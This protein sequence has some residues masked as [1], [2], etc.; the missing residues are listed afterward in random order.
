[1]GGL[2]DRIALL[3]EPQAPLIMDEQY[4]LFPVLAPRHVQVQGTVAEPVE[5]VPTVPAEQ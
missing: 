5:T 2:D 3:A 4:A 1:M